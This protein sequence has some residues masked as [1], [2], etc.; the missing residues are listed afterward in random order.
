M[1]PTILLIGRSGQIGGELKQM[2]PEIGNVIAPGRDALDLSVPSQIRSAIAGVRPQVIVNAAA[3]TAVDQAESDEASARAMN[4]EAPRVLAEEAKRLG[5]LLVHYS[6]DYVFDGEK[7]SPYTEDDVTHPLSVYGATK[8]EG[9][10][11][12][13]ESGA[14]HLILRTSWVYAPRG[15]NFLRTVIRLAT[16]REELRIVRDQTGAP[17]WSREVAA[18]TTR[19]LRQILDS[20]GAAW[21]DVRD[22]Y[23]MT[24]GGETNWA[25]FAEAILAEAA[26]LPKEDGWLA[27]AT[28][29]KPMVARGVIGITTAEYPTPARRPTYSVLSNARLAST[30]G[31]SL[32]DW[33]EQLQSAFA[34]RNEPDE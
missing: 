34:R 26:A 11:A 18:A 19:L 5:A 24:A 14:A 16:Q 7:R 21:A 6:T 12:I 25:E 13:R 9:E 29:G 32:P 31:L 30:F 28:N 3:D 2:L 17:T 33:R 8:L 4:A 15:R 22:T 23:H 27:V 1:N 10:I 20:P